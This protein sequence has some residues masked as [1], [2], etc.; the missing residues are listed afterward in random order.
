MDP[1]L[2]L[3]ECIKKKGEVAESDGEIVL[4]FGKSQE[5]IRFG[6]KTPTAYKVQKGQQLGNKG[7]DEPEY[8]TLHE[9]VFFFK[10]KGIGVGS[11][12]KSAKSAFGRFVVF[13]QRKTL[14]KYLLGEVA[15]TEDIDQSK[16]II[17]KEKKSKAD[18]TGAKPSALGKRTKETAKRT[19]KGKR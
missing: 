13:A 19:K 17:A 14:E 7:K 15:T 16:L 18:D 4:K 8:Y 3:R 12:M 9:V 2:K 5:E 10:N 1:L 11:Y 6:K